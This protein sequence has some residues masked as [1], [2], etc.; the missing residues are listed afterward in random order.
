VR[1]LGSSPVY[2]LT[3]LVLGCT[4]AVLW[5]DSRL[6]GDYRVLRE[7]FAG[8][9][10]RP[11]LVVTFQEADCENNLAFLAVLER[12]E[13]MD[14]LTAVALFSGTRGEYESVATR[15]EARFPHVRFARMA[16]RERRLLSQLGHPATPYW[17]LLD[18]SGAVRLSAPAPGNPLTYPEFS[19]SLR[20][21][22]RPSVRP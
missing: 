4:G 22:L 12:P 3:A 18:A 21:N 17:L 20:L 9:P 14:R 5:T 6:A 2:L 13:F 11:L 16:Q 7:S 19:E 15:L 10:A 8:S 1:K